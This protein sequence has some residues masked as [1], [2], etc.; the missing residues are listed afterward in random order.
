MRSIF[1]VFML[2]TTVT[3]TAASP[4][5]ASASCSSILIRAT[6]WL[7]GQGVNVYGC[8]YQCVELAAR[9]YSTRG[10]PTVHTADGGAHTIPEGSPGLDFFPNGSGY[11]PVPGD[12][13]VEEGDGGA[14]W[15][16]H[17]SVVDTVTST[18]IK[19]AEQNASSTGWHTYQ[20]T[21]SNV[22]GG[23]NGPVRGFSH[24]PEN[25]GTGGSA[26]GDKKADLVTLNNNG[27]SGTSMHV[28]TSSGSSFANQ[29]QWQNITWGWTGLKPLLGDANGD[30]K[31]DVVTLNNNG[32][33]GTSIHVFPSSGSSFGN[34]QQW[35]NVTWAWTGLTPLLGDVTGD[36]KADLVT[37]NNNGSNG[38][39]IHV[40]KST[41]SSFASQVMW[42]NTT[43]G[44]TG[45]KALLADATGDGKA[46]LITLNNAGA[47]GTT[48]QVFPSTGSSFS[49]PQQWRSTTWGWSGLKPLAGDVTGDGKADLIT[50]NNNGALG[51]SMHVFAS[52][53]SSFAAQQ[54][55]QNTAW[56]WTG[57]KPLLGDATG[58][59][60]ADVIT[61]NNNGS[62]GTS[63][64]VFAST[65]SSFAA[66]QQW[67]NITW[68]WTGLNPLI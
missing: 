63:I 11:V 20:R 7:G 17:V 64:H 3:A 25:M 14:N 30:G 10:W 58:D 29:Q 24:A 67:Q 37:L 39:S 65:G 33:S 56:G 52:T 45:I 18:T 15:Y 35:N 32:T 54:Q 12:L 59:G 36:G 51:T 62:S 8:G 40:F 43:W 26:T 44:Y 16:G 41:G 2:F 27:T 34:Q 46:D 31:A 55:W 22:T 23:Y 5:Q 50:L 6:D 38:T 48:M 42:R 60:K 4:E 49:T 9:L 13:I 61:L 21:G 57:L 53:G 47:A 1:G 66:Q 19:A 28:F 68:G